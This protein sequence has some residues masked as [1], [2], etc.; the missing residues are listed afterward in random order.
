MPISAISNNA[1]NVAQMQPN[2][3]TQNNAVQPQTASP[4]EQRVSSAPQPVGQSQ[5]SA[6]NNNATAQQN[7]QNEVQMLQEAAE[8]IS[9]H[10]NLKNSSLEFSVDQN[11]G[12]NVVKIVDKTT[13]EVVRQIPSEEAIHI[14][15]ASDELDEI[16]QG[17]LLSEQG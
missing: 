11:S 14:A 17:L 7:P 13:K 8:K 15:Q 16:R 1:V 4:V 9:A 3:R 12:K 6:K 5:N 2:P 10:L